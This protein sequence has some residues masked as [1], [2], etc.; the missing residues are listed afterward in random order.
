MI[1]NDIKS[2]EVSGIRTMPRQNFHCE[3]TL[4]RS[5]PEDGILIAP[6]NELHQTIAESAHA[7][8]KDNRVKAVRDLRPSRV[9]SLIR[10][11]ATPETRQTLTTEG[12]KEAR[13]KFYVPL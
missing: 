7:V 1:H 13:R 12:T 5:K 4:Q 8:V 3:C 11:S 10:Q 6:Q 2:I 9:T